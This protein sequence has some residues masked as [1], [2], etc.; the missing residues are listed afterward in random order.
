VIDQYLFGESLKWEREE[1]ERLLARRLAWAEHERRHGELRRSGGL[2]RRL[3]LV[4]LLLADRLQPPA[5]TSRTAIPVREAL[6]GR[7]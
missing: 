5:S 4:L 1:Q 7:A 3:A 6:N 2:R